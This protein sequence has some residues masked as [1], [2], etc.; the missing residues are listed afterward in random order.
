MT[1]L[2]A[3]SGQ[4]DDQESQPVQ[5]LIQLH[6]MKT[7]DI[8]TP[9]TVIFALPE[10]MR[11]TDFVKAIEDKPFSRIPIYRIQDKPGRDHRLCHPGEVLIAHLK[12]TTDKITLAEI[13]RPI[14]VAAD[15]TAVDALFRRFI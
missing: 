10:S 8:M 13:T 9:L 7:W 11:L 2:G 12:D 15:H 14:A 4:I 6:A 3:E 1:R 5:N